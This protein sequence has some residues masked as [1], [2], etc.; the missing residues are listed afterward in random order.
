VW[1]GFTHLI[2]RH[3]LRQDADGDPAHTRKNQSLS[4]AFL[5]LLAITFVFASFDWI[6]SLEPTWYSTMFPLYC[7]S[8]LFLGGTAAMTIIIV[9]FREKGLLT[10]ITDH[11][12]YEIGRVLCAAAT[13]W[14]YIWFCQYMLIY[15]TNIPEEAVY[16]I[17][18]FGGP[19]P[20][21]FPLN[22]V[23]NWLVP[24]VILIPARARR[25]PRWLLT[26]AFIILA[27]RWLDLYLLIMPAL[28]QPPSLG[29]PEI[30]IPAGLLALFILPMV[31]SFRKS[32][33]FPKK[34]PYL[35]ESTHLH[36]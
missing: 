9:Y 29:L 17:R 18:R 14:A 16:Y 7:F 3:S 5:V 31:N 32:E 27:A 33:P 12:L 35:V 30:L 4:A 36:V 34:D 25:S 20:L 21:L 2:R 11:H 23:L 19:L 15:Y 28:N 10:G 26:A 22:L 6:M 8:G 13:F 24:L 1:I